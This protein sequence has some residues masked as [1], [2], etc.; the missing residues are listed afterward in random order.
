MDGPDTSSNQT[1]SVIWPELWSAFAPHRGRILE[2][3]QSVS[4]NPNS[5]LCVWGA[6]RTTDLDLISL[7]RHYAKIELVD[8]NPSQTQQALV[9]RGF[10]EHSNVTVAPQTDLAGIN[11]QLDGLKDSPTEA[12]LKSIACLLYTS[13]SPRDA[14]LSRMPSSA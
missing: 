5:T 10:D 8:L 3:L 14:T 7:L 6:G 12:T 11:D 4:R 1:N 2:I 13:P 9:Q